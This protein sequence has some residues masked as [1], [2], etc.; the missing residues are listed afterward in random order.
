MI[1]SVGRKPL[2][3]IR[4]D[5]GH[6]KNPR[7]RGFLILRDIHDAIEVLFT[8]SNLPNDDLYFHPILFPLD[9]PVLNWEIFTLID[10]I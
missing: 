2:I 3:N 6:T 4:V 5:V 9:R 1:M 10:P 7:E 8:I